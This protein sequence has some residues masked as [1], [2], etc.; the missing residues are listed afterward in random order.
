MMSAIDDDEDDEEEE[1]EEAKRAGL[2][3]VRVVETAGA[4]T[5]KSIWRWVDEFQ[6][7]C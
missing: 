7:V 6:A 3:R 4:T 2:L 1:E 5:Q